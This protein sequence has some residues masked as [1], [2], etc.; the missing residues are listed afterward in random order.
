MNIGVKVNALDVEICHH[1]LLLKRFYVQTVIVNSEVRRV[2]TTIRFQGKMA[3]VYVPKFVNAKTAYIMLKETANT[4]VESSSVEHVYDFNLRAIYALYNKTN[5]SLNWRKL[6]LFSTIWKLV[7]MTRMPE[8]RVY[9]FL[10]SVF[11]NRDAM[12]ALILKATIC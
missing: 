10:C 11:F 3:R 4:I 9:M 8:A 6:S 1:V 7:K 5:E 2:L 12:T